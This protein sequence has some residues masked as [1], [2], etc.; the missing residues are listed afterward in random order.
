[1]T[2]DHKEAKVMRKQNRMEQIHGEK[3]AHEEKERL[4]VAKDFV[5]SI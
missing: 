3:R 5:I 1:M 2:L 4:H